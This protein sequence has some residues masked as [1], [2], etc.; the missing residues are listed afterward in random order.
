METKKRNNSIDLFRY[1]CAT[2]VVII[3]TEPFYHGDLSGVGIFLKEFLARVAVPF[4]FAVSGY[5]LFQ[6]IDCDPKA[7]FRSAWR[8]TKVYLLWS[9]PYLLIDGWVLKDNLPEFLKRTVLGIFLNGTY[10]HFWFFPGLIYATLIGGLIYRF[11]GWK[12]LAGLAMALYAIGVLGS[13]YP[14]PYLSD[15]FRWEHFTPIYRIAMTAI[16]FVVLGGWVARRGRDAVVSVRH[17]QS[18]DWW[19]LSGVGAAFVLEKCILI[20]T[21]LPI[22]HPNTWMLLPLTAV[23]LTLLLKHPLER[24]MT[25]AAHA[26]TCANFTYY[27]HMAFILIAGRGFAK[28]FGVPLD[29]FG[30]F[31][32]TVAVLTAIGALLHHVKW[33][34]KWLN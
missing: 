10:S 3:H 22:I 30:M 23:I 18:Y 5:F 20:W 12:P 27:I 16:P 19:I 21:G 11:L 7:P 4:F 6:K 29:G 31:I 26:R 28:V 32:V 17:N 2:L 15:M 24:H 8:L 14:I 9:V 33:I 25:L 34:R 13:T 1:I